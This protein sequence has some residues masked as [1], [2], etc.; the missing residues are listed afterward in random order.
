MDPIVEKM[1]LANINLLLKMH[2]WKKH[3]RPAKST[4]KMTDQNR[5]NKACLM[6]GRL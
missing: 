2:N 3:L 5:T 4:T 6:G 1:K